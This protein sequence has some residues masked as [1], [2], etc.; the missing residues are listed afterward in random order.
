MLLFHSLI[1]HVLAFIFMGCRDSTLL[2]LP[3]EMLPSVCHYLVV[4][5]GYYYLVGCHS[6]YFQSIT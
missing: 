1:S 3:V 5:S 2:M 6:S 4:T